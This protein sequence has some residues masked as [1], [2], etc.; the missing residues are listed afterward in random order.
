MRSARLSSRL[1]A[2]LAFHPPPT[3]LHLRSTL[4]PLLRSFSTRLPDTFDPIDDR[5]D[6]LIPPSERGLSQSEFDALPAP[7]RASIRRHELDLILAEDAVASRRPSLL[8]PPLRRRCRRHRRG[9]LQRSRPPHPLPALFPP[10]SPPW[11]RPLHCAHHLLH[12]RRTRVASAADGQPRV[13]PRAPRLRRLPVPPLFA[14]PS[15]L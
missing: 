11:H 3:Q 9:R 2:A 1:G 13:H 6:S 4:L 10:P 7:Q 8:P 14:T 5:D 12:V 15:S